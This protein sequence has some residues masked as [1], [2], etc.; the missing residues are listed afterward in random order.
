METGSSDI[1]W[2][3]RKI[4]GRKMEKDRDGKGK[5]PPNDFSIAYA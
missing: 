1:E 2:R 4:K 5:T 3:K